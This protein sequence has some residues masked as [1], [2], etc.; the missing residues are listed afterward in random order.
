MEGQTDRKGSIEGTHKRTREE[1]RRKTGMEEERRDPKTAGGTEETEGGR[2]RQRDS[3]KETDERRRMRE[4]PRDRKA[5]RQRWT[6]NGHQRESGRP[7]GAAGRE[8]ARQR[9]REDG[10][11]WKAM[12]RWTVRQDAEDRWT[13]T[14]RRRWMRTK[15]RGHQT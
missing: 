15:G 4:G 9:E 14:E 10:D 11:G 13:D 7:G 2:R 12:D 6:Q 5:E 1:T 8:G 3:K